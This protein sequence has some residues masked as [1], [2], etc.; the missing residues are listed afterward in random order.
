MKFP[1]STKPL[2][3]AAPRALAL[4]ALAE[5]GLAAPQAAGLCAPGFQTVV[6]QPPEAQDG[7]FSDA[8]CDF[9]GGGQSLAENF[10]LAV[11][12]ELGEIRVWGGY[13]PN[14]QVVPDSFTVAVHA[15]EDGAPG[16]TLFEQSDVAA[17]RVPTGET[18]FGVAEW[19]YTLTLATSVALE[20]GTYW[21]EV[22]NDTGAGTDDWFWERGAP[23]IGTFSSAFAPQVPGAT[24]TAFADEL[25]WTLCGRS[26]LPCATVYCDDVQNPMNVADIYI[27]GCALD[28]G[29][30]VAM[31]CAPPGQFAYLMLGNGT[32]VASMPPGAVGDL[33]LLGGTCLGRYVLDLGVID[34]TGR[35]EV[36]IS[37]SASGGP[38][39]GLPSCPGK[40]HAGETWS[41]QF[42][43]RQGGG[44]PS[45][46]SSA[47]TVTF[48]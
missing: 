34:S 23:H 12:M 44:Q 37:D 26:L 11:R 36:D 31:S 24:W 48:L 28:A 30:T 16:A 18:A 14:D 6:E 22:F 46:F 32:A 5:V 38:N 20:P 2:R 8:S 19:E 17:S 7:F 43:H 13:F 39:F 15:D 25:A 41:F 40:I 9:C 29:T 4:L 35:F 21:L 10:T 27:S 47:L 3:S 45:T 33:C 42:W 1:A